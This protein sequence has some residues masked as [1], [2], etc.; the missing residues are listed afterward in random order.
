MCLPVFPVLCEFTMLLKYLT[1]FSV[2]RPASQQVEKHRVQD[3]YEDI[4]RLQNTRIF[5]WISLFWAVCVFRT[6]FI[7]FLIFI[8]FEHMFCWWQPV[9]GFNQQPQFRHLRYK[10]SVCALWIRALLTASNFLCR[11]CINIE[12]FFPFRL[13]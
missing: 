8:D 2:C 10:N 9:E 11:L 5:L 7:D 6:V 1:G 3:L 12:Y 13:S 4:W